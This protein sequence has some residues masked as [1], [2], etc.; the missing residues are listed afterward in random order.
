MGTCSKRNK[1]RK[2]DLYSLIVNR[3]G[4]GSKRNI[5][6]LA[7]LCLEELSCSLI[8]GED[9]GS[10][11]ELCAH[12]CYSCSFRHGQRKYAFTGILHYLAHA[13][14][15]GEDLKH[16]QNYVLCGDP[17]VEPA[18]ELYVYYL[19]H[20]YVVCAA[21]H[22]NSNIE[23]AR[24]ACEHTDTAACGGMAVGAYERLAGLSEALKVYLVADTVSGTREPDAVLLCDASDKAVIVGILKAGLERV[25]IDVSDRALRLYAVNAHSLKLEICHSAGCVLRKSLV[26]AQT[27]LGSL[28]HFSVNDMIFDYFFGQCE[29]HLTSSCK[30]VFHT[31]YCTIYNEICQYFD[32]K[33]S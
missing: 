10:S 12:I 27:Y 11:A 25:M 7:S 26:Y 4:I 1:F 20:R 17:V 28:D 24:A 19:R 8:G 31:T 22:S 33:N 2:I 5:V 3:V 6:L 16:L 13:A 29:S 9:R 23:S 21:A 14:L 32:S 30:I 18:G 15:Y